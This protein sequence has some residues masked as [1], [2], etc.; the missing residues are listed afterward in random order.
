MQS[1]GRDECNLGVGCGHGQLPRPIIR[2]DG[3]F[4][5]DGTYQRGFTPLLLGGRS[6]AFTQASSPR[7]KPVGRISSTR[8]VPEAGTEVWE[9]FATIKYPMHT[10]ASQDRRGGDDLGSSHAILPPSGRIRRRSLDTSDAAAERRLA[11]IVH[12]PSN[13]FPS[14]HTTDTGRSALR[15]RVRAVQLVRR[16]DSRGQFPND[17]RHTR[18]TAT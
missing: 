13:Q 16:R 10:S 9:P 3:T 7:R 15:R 6:D 14:S 11:V 18:D 1:P 8:G 2:A 4:N 5:V 12:R 17:L